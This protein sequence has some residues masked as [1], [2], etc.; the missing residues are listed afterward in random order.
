VRN[1]SVVHWF[2]LS[3]LAAL[4]AAMLLRMLP[5]FIALH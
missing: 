2:A 4:T 5:V 3:A 1:E